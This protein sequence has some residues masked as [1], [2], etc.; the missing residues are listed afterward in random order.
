MTQF[1][2][3][4]SGPGVAD[5]AGFPTPWL[6]YEGNAF[7]LTR[8][9]VVRLADWFTPLGLHL[10]DLARTE[11]VPDIAAAMAGLTNADVLRDPATAVAQA[12]EVLADQEIPVV[13][14]HRPVV[15]FQG[16][17]DT[18]VPP[19]LTA[20]TAAQLGAPLI[21]VPGADHFTLP[22]V[23]AGQVVARTGQLF[24]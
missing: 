12:K 24:G 3:L 7:A 20:V 22:A 17:A 5:P 4:L 15:L 9:D 16:T 6:P 2:L 1:G 13:A 10:A 18:A 23:V 19:P 21:S 11:C 14:R 8:P